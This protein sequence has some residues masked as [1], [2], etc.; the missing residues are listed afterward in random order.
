[1]NSLTFYPHRKFRLLLFP[2][3]LLT[4]SWKLS[5]LLKLTSSFY[6]AMLPL[7]SRMIKR[8]NVNNDVSKDSPSDAHGGQVLSFNIWHISASLVV[9]LR[10]FLLCIRCGIERF[11][12]VSASDIQEVAPYKMKFLF[13]SLLVFAFCSFV[14]KYWM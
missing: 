11:Y 14:G 7:V 9:W 13:A 4:K 1:M 2:L 6:I 12:R 10:N 8:K 5:K 3:I